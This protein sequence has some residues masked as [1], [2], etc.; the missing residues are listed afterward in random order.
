[1]RTIP[2]HFERAALD[3]FVVMP[4]HIHGIIV[5]ADVSARHAVPLPAEMRSA[6][7]KQYGFTD[8]ELDFIINDDIKCHIGQEVDM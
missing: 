1:L 5:T 8:E 2:V 7:S 4:N 3:A 6:L